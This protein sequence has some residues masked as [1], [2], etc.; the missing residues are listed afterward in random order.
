LGD[1]RFTELLELSAFQGDLGAG[2]PLF[3]SKNGF[4]ESAIAEC[5]GL[6]R[7]RGALSRL[8]RQGQGS[9][10]RG[11]GFIFIEVVSTDWICRS[12]T[13][14]GCF[15]DM[16]SKIRRHREYSTACGV[17]NAGRRLHLGFRQ[18]ANV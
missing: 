8:R 13:R 4:Q 14:Q 1:V 11:Q 3:L 15:T 12:V 5:R 2:S 16:P 6:R 18:H 7:R 9:R 17:A 10:G